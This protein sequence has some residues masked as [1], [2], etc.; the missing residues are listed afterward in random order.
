MLYTEFRVGEKEY[1]LRLDTRA[2]VSLEKVLGHNPLSIFTN[3][4]KEELP[5]VEVMV[6]VLHY[7]LQPLQDNIQLEN[8]YDIFDAWLDEG[9]IVS[10]F[11]GVIVEVFKASGLI[12]RDKKEKN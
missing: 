7:A 3:A 9:H 11:I 5:T 2:T 1:K 6:T 10:E 8:T 4:S 12:Q